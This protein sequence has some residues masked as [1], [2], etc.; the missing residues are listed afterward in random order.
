[1]RVVLSGSTGRAT[2]LVFDFDQAPTGFVRTLDEVLGLH[3]LCSTF[4]TSLVERTRIHFV[5]GSAVLAAARRRLK[6]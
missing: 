4:A 2:E 3:E 1:M 6:D 5:Y